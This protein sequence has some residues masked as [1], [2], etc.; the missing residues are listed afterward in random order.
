[1]RTLLALAFTL[2]STAALAHPDS[3]PASGLVHGF[4]HP[5]SGLDHV[6][7]MLAV[8]LLAAVLGG[9]ALLLVPASFVVMLAAGFLLGTSGVALPFL[10]FG[11][12]LSVL[13]IGGAAALGRSLPLAG[14]MAL[15]G[16]FAVFH[17]FAHGAE[18]PLGASGTGY[19]LGFVATTVLLHAA[20][21]LVATLGAT[22]AGH[23][24]RR[25]AQ[26]AGGAVALGG[27]GLLAGWL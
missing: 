1:M 24:G 9:R 20:G 11:I 8:G 6:L 15:A 5:L 18:M 17:G 21:I 10:E 4:L 13:V 16:A 7:A 26:L 22:L 27:A 19:A 25:L 12:A 14:A 3:G 23:R 2:V